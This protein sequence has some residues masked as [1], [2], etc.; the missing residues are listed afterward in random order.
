MDRR[1]ALKALIT[2]PGVAT[3]AVVDVQPADVIVVE[4]DEVVSADHVA[5][6]RAQLALVWPDRKIVIF[7]KGYRMRI[8][9]NTVAV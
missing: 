4:C 8:A 6:I 5:K 2:L 7:D 9:R 3:I 1:T